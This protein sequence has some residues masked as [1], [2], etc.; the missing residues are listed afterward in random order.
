[1]SIWYCRQV[2][3]TLT[4][5]YHKLGFIKINCFVWQ[6]LE[7]SRFRRAVTLNMFFL[8]CLIDVRRISDTDKLPKPWKIHALNL[9]KYIVQNKISNCNES[10]FAKF[11]KFP[12]FRTKSFFVCCCLLY[13]NCTLLYLLVWLCPLYERT[14]TFRSGLHLCTC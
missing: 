12:S 1:M 10:W 5:C 13:I 9:N 7:V 2:S 4:K 14:E 3:K 6:R 11:R 8:F